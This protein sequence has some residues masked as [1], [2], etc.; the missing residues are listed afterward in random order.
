MKSLR[1]RIAVVTLALA[2]LAASPSSALP[3]WGSDEV[4]AARALAP[5]P[6]L[7]LDFSLSDAAAG[8]PAGPQQGT[9]ALAANF[10]HKAAG[11]DHV[12][13]DYALCKT[14][15]WNETERRLSSLNCHALP[16]FL[17]NELG[18]RLMLAKVLAAADLK[19][20]GDLGPIWTEMELGLAGQEP[21]PL[22]VR[23]VGDRTEYLHGSTVAASVS[24]DAGAAS[25]YEMARLVRLLARHLPM[26]PQIRADI[27][28]RGS[29]PARIEVRYASLG[30]PPRTTVMTLANLRRETIA[31]PLPAGLTSSL[32]A[33]AA[34]DPTD[35]GAAIRRALTVLDSGGRD[36]PPSLASLS[37]RVK[38]SRD[39]VEA[40]MLFLNITQ[41]Y[42][43]AMR[44]D[45]ALLDAIIPKI[46]ASL[47]DQRAAQFWQANALSG[48][49][50]APG[51]RE[52]AAKYLAGAK[53]LDALPFGT[54]R[55]VTYAN[56]ATMTK[57]SDQWPVEIRSAMPQ[58][59]VDNYW[60]HIAV[61]PWAANAYM[62]AAST[63]VFDPSNAWLAYDLGRAIDP[64]WRTS[65]LGGVVKY[66]QHLEAT[67]PDFF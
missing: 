39:P 44:S 41:Q 48:D 12:I 17:I 8:K 61:Y 66:E 16:A 59:L 53:S 5:Q 67:L 63:Y 10:N 20:H 38:A 1:V 24:G 18:N 40:L 28:K 13:D 19:E 47:Q 43:G 35:R 37:T 31:Y 27:A 34:N 49:A 57:S 3:F 52:A 26:H 51:D 46:R 36:G 7:V 64:Q 54:F 2:V 62:D 15:R 30:V 50:K 23:T 32:R 56:L 65:V 4:R 21:A 60:R 25:P 14:L 33:E 55:Y 6:A 11:G 58:N 22:K 9:I 42:G 29:L 45:P